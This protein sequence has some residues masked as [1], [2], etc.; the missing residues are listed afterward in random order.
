MREEMKHLRFE[1]KEHVGLLTMSRPESLNALNRSV[2]GEL[3]DFLADVALREGIRVLL[4][5]G[6]GEEAFCAGA[7]IK[8]MQGLDLLGMAKFCDLGQRVA[9][10]L[11]TMEGVTI[12]AVNGY[13]LGGGLEMAMA[14][15]FIYASET[16]RLGMPEVTLGIIPGFGGTQR[17]ARG[18]GLSRAKEMIFSGR[19]IAAHE[20][21]SVG[22]VNKVLPGEVLLEGCFDIASRICRNGPPAVLEAKRAI[23]GARQHL[24]ERGLDLEKQAFLKAF[25]TED[26]KRRMAAF[27]E[28][29]APKSR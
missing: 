17:L 28:K 9:R 26:C 12:A 7:D 16:A 25:D 4:L 1:K 5:T 10:R 8:E 29:K 18:V 11:E 24:L 3:D 2:L 23:G 14:C 22:L 27:T 21:Y 19:A 20:A 6:E 15:D 13:A